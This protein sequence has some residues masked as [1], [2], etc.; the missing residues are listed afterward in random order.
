[1]APESDRASAGGPATDVGDTRRRILEMAREEISCAGWAAATSGC[2]A[3][4]AAVSKALIHYHF[5]DKDSLLRAVAIACRENVLMRGSARGM[6]TTHVNPVDGFEEWLEAELASQDL[7]IALQL[8]ASGRGPVV[9]AADHVLAAVRSELQQQV[10]QVFEILG[11]VPTVPP[12]SVVDLFMTV[13]EGAALIP[14]E[15]VARL[16]QMVATIWF[17]LLSVSE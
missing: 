8:R 9:R 12:T 4:R 14:I 16:R 10:D 5:Q 6:R 2:L 13:T 11:V 7:R 3:K 15:P 1:M 17:S